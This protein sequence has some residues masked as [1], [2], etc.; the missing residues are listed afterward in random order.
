MLLVWV[1][2]GVACWLLIA[3]FAWALLRAAALPDD[4]EGRDAAER[5]LASPAPSA[6]PRAEHGT[7]RRA[8]H[9]TVW[10]VPALAVAVAGGLAAVRLGSVAGG[11][12]VALVALAA[13]VLVLGA[14]GLRRAASARGRRARDR[15]LPQGLELAL[16]LLALRDPAAGA[17]AAAVAHYARRLARDAGLSEEQQRTVHA[18]GLLHDIGLPSAS[19]AL[20]AHAREL[21]TTDRAIRAHP[22]AGAALVRTLPGF[23]A[24]ADAIQAHHERI[25]GRGYPDGLG[26]TEIPV[27]ARIVAIAEV[28]DAL[29]APAADP[30][31]GASADQAARELR[32]VAGTQLDAHLVDVFLTTV[33]TPL[34]RRSLEPEL[35]VLD[36]LGSEITA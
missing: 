30:H 20:P 4:A 34:T 15:R 33:H 24:V 8:S 35:A 2:L 28:Y 1:G 22:A 17:H 3:A 32:R 21:A 26:G 27:T 31:S 7:H 12:T 6:A 19:Q 36:P 29:T 16:R 11:V 10:L 9:T 5:G 13:G 25:D 14:V 23:D 18:A